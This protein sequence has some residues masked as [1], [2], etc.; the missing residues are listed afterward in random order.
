MIV[1]GDNEGA[2]IPR[3]PY[4]SLLPFFLFS[5]LSIPFTIPPSPTP[6]L[7]PAEGHRR[8]QELEGLG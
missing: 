2:S 4:F 7:K 3:I 5:I 1:V 6:S 8:S